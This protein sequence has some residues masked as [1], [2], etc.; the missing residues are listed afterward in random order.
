MSTATL[1]PPRARRRF[2]PKA[3]IK[4]VL[5][6][7]VGVGALTFLFASA[8][9]ANNV[10]TSQ[11]TESVFNEAATLPADML[12]AVTWIPDTPDLP[13]QMEPL[14]RTDITDAWLRAWAQLALVADGGDTAGL[15]VYFSNSALDGVLASLPEI[16]GAPIHQIGH[17]LRL[18]FYSEDGQVVALEATNTRLL[19]AVPMG[20]GSVAWYDTVE[21]WEA[22]LVLEDGNWRIQHWV[23]R[24][25]EGA[26]WTDPAAPATAAVPAAV[27]GMNYYPRDTPWAG[28]W[29]AFDAEVVTADLDRIAELGLDSVRIFVPFAETDARHVRAETLE[30]VVEFL[31]LAEA[32]GI[33]V[34]VTLFDGRTDHRPSRWDGDEAHLEGL[35]EVLAGHPAIVMWDLKNEPDRDVGIHGVSA[36]LVHA[37][38][39]HM[40]RYLRSLDPATPITVG[41][42]TGEA[43]AAAPP[44]GDAVS[45]HHYFP[46]ADLEP[47]V[48]AIREVAP[49]KPVLLT[50]FG[51]PTWNTVFPG[52]HTEADQAAYYADVL[53]EVDRLDI[54]GFMAWT[55]WDLASAP[56][57]AGIFPWKTGP[58]THLG[59]LRPDG[60]AKPAAAVL[61]EGADLDAVARPGAL[62]RFTKPF[63]IVMLVVMALTFFF[64][65]S[66][67]TGFFLMRHRRR[68]VAIEES[69]E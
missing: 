54:D 26:W 2:G 64:T 34:V 49:D 21:T 68:A 13:R 12:D 40:A 10:S 25:A 11:E 20:D 24:S 58:Q 4:L 16:A 56:P 35:T 63:W 53:T 60:T 43:A 41:W 38:L 17:D 55:L 27:R 59:V 48:N 6:A 62:Q 5:I 14:T 1:V 67:G 50:E 28:F 65:T 22:V 47:A 69:S 30:P 39:G 15:E 29:A 18:D 19:R 33:D 36:D 3:L 44:H 45:F 32:Q 66:A 8:F 42:A 7:V 23:R 46:A 52:G 57:D 31:D 61:A 37:W 51:L 9:A